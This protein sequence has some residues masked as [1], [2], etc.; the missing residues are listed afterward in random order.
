MFCY[1]C[2][3]YHQ[4]NA[5]YRLFLRFIIFLLQSRSKQVKSFKVSFISTFS[6]LFKKRVSLKVGVYQVRKKL[7]HDIESLYT[8]KKNKMVKEQLLI[9]WI[10]VYSLLTRTFNIVNKN[11]TN[12]YEVETCKSFS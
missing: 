3:I 12:G 5:C 6:S 1:V 2:I 4:K 11:S 7:R 10:F 9:S 8:R